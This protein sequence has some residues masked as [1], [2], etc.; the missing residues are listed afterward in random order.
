MAVS[1]WRHQFL[2][3]SYNSIRTFPTLTYICES[4]TLWIGV[5]ETPVMISF[6][7][8]RT[9]CELDSAACMHKSLQLMLK[10]KETHLHTEVVYTVFSE[11]KTAFS[12]NSAFL[13]LIFLRVYTLY[14]Y[15]LSISSRDAARR[16]FVF[17]L[18][19]IHDQHPIIRLPITL[20]SNLNNC[21]KL[22][23]YFNND[24]YWFN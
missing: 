6:C 10:T 23:N 19:S 16:R 3:T 2:L 20:F 7:W 18:Y 11:F 21:C 1:L 12:I 15:T 5:Y 4:Y 22:C 8:S 17:S 9:K 14:M 13:A 24:M